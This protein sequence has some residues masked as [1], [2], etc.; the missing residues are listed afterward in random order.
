MLTTPDG[1]QARIALTTSCEHCG[2]KEIK[3]FVAKNQH[4]SG[5]WNEELQFQC[6]QQYEYSP[7]FRTITITS[8]CRRDKKFKDIADNNIEYRDKLVTMV[9]KKTGI[10]DR[11]RARL[12]DDLK[13]MSTHY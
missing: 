13:M 4:C 7:N 3:K 10:S 8:T 12:I 6:D 1:K 11:F 5:Q 9:T 2:C